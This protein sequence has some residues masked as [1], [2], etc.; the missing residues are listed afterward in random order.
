MINNPTK[1]A[2]LMKQYGLS[3]ADI[4]RA[5]HLKPGNASAS[6]QNHHRT[7]YRWLK[8]EVQPVM[9]W[10]VLNIILQNKYK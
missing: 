3:Q 9:G 4:A 6:G 8:G 2:A 5:C 7:V 10:E 1:L